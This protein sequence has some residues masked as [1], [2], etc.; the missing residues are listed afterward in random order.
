MHTYARISYG[1]G[2]TTDG[3]H[4]ILVYRSDYQ[5][6]PFPKPSGRYAHLP[7]KSIRG[8]FNTP[9]NA[10]WPVVGPAICDILK[11]FHLRRWSIDPARFYTHGLEGDEAQGTLGPVVVWIGVLPGSTS[12]ETAH[13]IS[14][15]ILAL[16][17]DN[18]IQDV[19]VE[20][21]ESETEQLVGPPL[22]RHVGTTNATHHV[23]RF[24]TALLGIPLTTKECE[25]EDVQGTLT[26][27]F[28]ENRDK[29]G[30]QSNRVLGL[31]CC[32][33]LRPKTTTT[34]EFRGGGDQN[35]VRVGGM[36]RFQQ[37]LD[38]ITEAIADHSLVANYLTREYAEL[39]ANEQDDKTTSESEKIWQK[40]VEEKE[41]VTALEALYKEVIDSWFNLR[42]QRNI[43]Y[44]E[45]APAISVADDTR[46]TADWGVFV[47]AEAIVK[48][49]FEGNV[50]DLGSK[51][52]PQ[53]LTA[54]FC[55]MAGGRNTFKFPTQRKLR[56]VACAT[57]DD[58]AHPA[59]F[60]ADGQPCLIVGKDGNTTGLTVGR[61]AGMV[62]FLENEVGVVSR[63]LGIYNTGL[64]AVEPFS[65]KGDSGSIVWHMRDGKAHMVGQ[66]HSGRN[67][68]VRAGN[69]L[70][71]AT[72]AWY[73]LEQVKSKYEYADFYRSAW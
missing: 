63:E 68:G 6:T 49:H 50:V 66:L 35:L 12:T 23:R 32:H 71:Y 14:Q 5:S 37:G 65:K 73:L 8:V 36:S 26:L 16:L 64:K 38:G 56:I 67:K 40:L 46:Y 3:D 54:M 55:P 17:R 7:V 29:N 9:L 60:D 70:T 45:Y 28:H 48:P 10:A 22:L 19:V 59:E 25:D 44:V 21:R 72:P 15:T 39:Q 43:G 57:E 11:A 20:F 61:Y 47:A 31:T 69:Y 30:E 13:D 33:V 51:Y 53:E 34:Y 24:L 18:D 1:H 62:S 52:T 41:A 4:P 42:L 58:L 27:W 2:I